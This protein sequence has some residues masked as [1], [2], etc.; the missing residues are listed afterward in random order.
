MHK[1]WTSVS[2]Q[3]G[4][5][6]GAPPFHFNGEL[7]C[8][9]QT[10]PLIHCHCLSFQACVLHL[11]S[12]HL[13]PTFSHLLPRVIFKHGDNVPGRAKDVEWFGKAVIVDEASIHGKYAHEQDQ[14]APTEKS[15]PD[16]QGKKAAVVNIHL[17]DTPFIKWNSEPSPRLIGSISLLVLAS[18]VLFWARRLSSLMTIQS[19]KPSMTAP[20]PQSPN[21]TANR[22][23][24]VMIV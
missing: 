2:E 6:P 19:A 14:V 18:L 1:P 12:F 9:Y 11:V 3:E 15:V 16:L 17:L 21:I 20:W 10:K 22:K 24:K 23:G 8:M 5:F 4:L 7:I 13:F